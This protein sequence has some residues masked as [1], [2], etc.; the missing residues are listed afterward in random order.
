[1]IDTTGALAGF[2]LPSTRTSYSVKK[3]NRIKF[4]LG[5]FL[6]AYYMILYGARCG[7]SNYFIVF[8]CTYINYFI[9][10]VHGTLAPLL[11]VI[12][13]SYMYKNVVISTFFYFA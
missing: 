10:M 5:V 12:S 7:A 2:Y 4:W 13:C 1:M 3:A 9:K 6:Y 11:Y 8:K